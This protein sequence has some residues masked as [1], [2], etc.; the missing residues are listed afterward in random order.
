MTVCPVE[1]ARRSA[2]AAPDVADELADGFAGIAR[3]L[4][5]GNVDDALD[6]LAESLDPLQRFLTFLRIVTDEVRRSDGPLGAVVADYTT[7]LNLLLDKVLAYLDARD[8]VG[9]TLALEHGMTV[10]LSDYRRFA[11]RVEDG[12]V[13]AAIVRAAAAAA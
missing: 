1:L 7:R 9:L 6:H 13:P 2:A 3:E 11:K 5:A 4:L 10:A 12:F 8:L